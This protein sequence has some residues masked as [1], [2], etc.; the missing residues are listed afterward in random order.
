VQDSEG[1]G[2]FPPLPANCDQLPI[3]DGK[4]DPET[5]TTSAGFAELPAGSARERTGADPI[6]QGL[7]SALAAWAGEADAKRLR[8]DLRRVLTLL[9]SLS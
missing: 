2:D 7:A 6:V 8:A 1:S 9:E 3:S 4:A 5:E